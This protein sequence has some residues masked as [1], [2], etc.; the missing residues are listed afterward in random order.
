V[1]YLGKERL[2]GVECDHLKFIQEQ[3]DW[4]LW[5]SAGTK[6]VVVQVISDM[7][8]SFSGMTGEM[9]PPKGM[10]MVV[11]NRFAGW[12]V[13]GV[14]PAEMFEFV[15]P[16]GARKTDMLFEGEDEKAAEI[17]VSSGEKDEE[18][19]KGIEKIESRE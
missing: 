6:P 17:P 2:D 14:I 13:D 9:S 5:V 10:K 8:K 1:S 18:S 3:F 19:P 16:P 11:L 15:P 4:E 12:E 7:T